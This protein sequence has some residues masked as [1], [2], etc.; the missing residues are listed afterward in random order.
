MSRLQV[1]ETV[2]KLLRELDGPAPVDDLRE[3]LGSVLRIPEPTDR[4]IVDEVR[5]LRDLADRHG[6]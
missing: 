2:R 6:L 3:V 4:S 1:D 5:R